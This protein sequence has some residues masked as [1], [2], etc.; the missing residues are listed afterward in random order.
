VATSLFAF[1]W[2]F[3]LALLGGLATDIGP[4]YRGLVQP[5]WKPPDTWFGP[6]WTLIYLFTGTALVLA[7]R[8]SG[9]PPHRRLLLA[10]CALNGVLNVLWSWLFF[11]LQR[12]D[13]ALAE[14]MLLWASI[15][16]LMLTCHRSSRLAAVLM[17]PYLGWVTFAATLNLAVVRL[18]APFAS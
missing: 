18:N 16:L 1:A 11:R 13:W 5:A 2:V 10:T 6:A 12:P 4:W 8:A 14:V 9:K 3:T 17:L 7:W 15:V